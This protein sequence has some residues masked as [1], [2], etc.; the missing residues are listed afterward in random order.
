MHGWQGLNN[1]PLAEVRIDSSDLATRL[2]KQFAT[3]KKKSGHDFEKIYLANS[4]IFFNFD[5]HGSLLFHV[6]VSLQ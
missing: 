2:R 5:P 3:I 1:I 6:A 4:I